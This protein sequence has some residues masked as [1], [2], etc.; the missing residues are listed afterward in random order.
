MQ[1]LCNERTYYVLLKMK[2]KH[3]KLIWRFDDMKK[4]SKDSLPI[5]CNTWNVIEFEMLLYKKENFDILKKK[6]DFGVKRC[7]YKLSAGEMC[8]QCVT[9]EQPKWKKPF[10]AL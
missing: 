10:N 1:M 7:K 6:N 2:K 4:F 9:H 8:P 5:E 3:E